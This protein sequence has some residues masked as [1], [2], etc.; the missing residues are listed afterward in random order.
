MTDKKSIIQFGEGN[1]NGVLVPL[2]SFDCIIDTDF[3][4]LNLIDR[5]YLDKDVFSVD[6]FDTHHTNKAMVK[7]LYERKDKNPLLLCMKNPDINKANEM[8]KDFMKERY[9]DILD[10]S[11]ATE[12]YNLISTLK[13]YGDIRVSVVCEN[14]FEVR[15]LKSLKNTSTVPIYKMENL[16]S[17]DMF[18]Q[19]YFKYINGFYTQ[20]LIK[21]LNTKNI[22]FAAYDFNLNPEKDE[23]DEKLKNEYLLAFQLTRND[24]H[25]FDLYNRS[26]LES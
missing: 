12:V 4:L 17:P 11:M 9:K 24:L 26:K 13:T 6:F 23:E 21:Y 19:F 5:E 14:E 20:M 22:Y 3:G 2:I 15:L 18:Q 1:T 16:P 25:S 10:V 8:Y 7:A